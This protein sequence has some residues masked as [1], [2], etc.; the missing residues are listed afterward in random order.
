MA[1]KNLIDPLY[2]ATNTASLLILKFI[3]AAKS[4]LCID[5]ADK[6]ELSDKGC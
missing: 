4:L 5:F 2:A 1:C 3:N 6:S